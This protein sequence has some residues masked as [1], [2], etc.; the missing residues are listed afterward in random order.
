MESKISLIEKI[1][2]EVI[3]EKNFD[4]KIKKPLTSTN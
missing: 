1:F 3:T 4:G 2:P